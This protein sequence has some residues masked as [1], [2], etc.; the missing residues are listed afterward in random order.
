MNIILIDDEESSLKVL[1]ILLQNYFPEFSIVA[2]AQN[3]A[4]GE[5]IIRQSPP[6]IL[7]LDIML[8]DG[9]GFDL[10]R[11]LGKTNFPVVFVTAYDQYAIQALRLSAADY[12]LK[13]IH[14]QDLSFAIDKCLKM[15]D[16]Y[17]QNSIDYTELLPAQPY[18]NDQKILVLNK[19]SGEY[20]HYKKIICLEAD[21]NYS[22]IYT[23]QQKKISISKTL[24][25][26]EE[27]LCDTSHYFLR[28]HKSFIINTQQIKSI[29]KKEPAHIVL[30]NNQVIE[31]PQR[32]RTD[33]L[34]ILAN[35]N[36]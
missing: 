32:K 30:Q 5:A 6:D 14:K 11:N 20:I 24:K 28:V 19:Y 10:L 33:I 9:T 34:D 26:M 21:S 7:F 23:T 13:P 16:F 27:I 18:E 8:S 12:L 15:K 22:V 36:N 17:A 3:I 31:I 35:M 29:Q 2:T 4:D 25:E 1:K